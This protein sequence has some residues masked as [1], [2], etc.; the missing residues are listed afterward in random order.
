MERGINEVFKSSL[1]REFKATSCSK[2]VSNKGG[3][4]ISIDLIP[5]ST[6][7]LVLN[8]EEKR[9]VGAIFCLS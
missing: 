2:C 7:Q 4:L 1:E 6:F 5:G 3:L 8:Q 9:D